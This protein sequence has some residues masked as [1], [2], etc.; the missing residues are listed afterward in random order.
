[1]NLKLSLLSAF[2]VMCYS[3]PSK[4]NHTFL[5]DSLAETTSAHRSSPNTF[6]GKHDDKIDIATLDKKQE[7][8]KTPYSIKSI[9]SKAI[10]F[11]GYFNGFLSN[12]IQNEEYNITGTDS[13]IEHEATLNLLYKDAVCKDLEYAVN[14]SLKKKFSNELRPR[15]FIQLDHKTYGKLELANY[16]KIQDDILVN[17][18][19]IRAGSRNAWDRSINT[20]LRIDDDER[21]RPSLNKILTEYN[22][23]ETF[24]FKRDVA[25]IAYYYKP[26]E[27]LTIGTSFAPKA[28]YVKIEDHAFNYKNIIKFGAVYKFKTQDPLDFRISF[29]NEYG[30]Q[31][32]DH[33]FDKEV[34]DLNTFNIGFLLKYLRFG[35]AGTAGL[36]NN[37]GACRNIPTCNTNNCDNQFY[38]KPKT[39]SYFDLAIAY[40]LTQK[41]KTSLS[42]FKSFN[43]QNYAQAENTNLNFFTNNGN[44]IYPPTNSQS[45]QATFSNISLAFDYKL[46][47]EFLVP[48]LEFNKFL[49]KDNSAILETSDLKRK[50][51][52]GFVAVLGLKAKF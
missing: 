43:A 50:D 28:Y 30:V 31:A 42:F 25:N 13:Q 46:H 49:V 10:E 15:T 52:D 51:N 18:N 40:D 47:K 9:N 2:F 4:I 12:T 22:I 1:M 29:L 17:A 21:Y 33:G 36:W 6:G 48:Y 3:A 20:S 37:T 41:L 8:K 32:R 44:G 16:S 38:A 24:G 14:F 45:G 23:A 19:W 11:N 39:T 35:F 34:S 7:E 26:F 5:N 27:N